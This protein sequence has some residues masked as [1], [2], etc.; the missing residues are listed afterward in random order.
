LDPFIEI[1]DMINEYED[2]IL[3]IFV[4]WYNYDNAYY[5]VFNGD[6]ISVPVIY[7][8]EHISEENIITYRTNE[9]LVR[10][11]NLRCVATFVIYPELFYFL[12]YFDPIEM[13]EAD[14]YG[15][16]FRR[17]D[18]SYVQTLTGG[19]KHYFHAITNDLS[20]FS[21][22]SQFCTARPTWM[23]VFS[24]SYV[25]V[26]MESGVIRKTVLLEKFNGNCAYSEEI[27][28][29]CSKSVVTNCTR[30]ELVDQFS[31]G[32]SYLEWNGITFNLKMSDS[33]SISVPISQFELL[34]PPVSGEYL[35]PMAIEKELLRA[36]AGNISS[37][38]AQLMLYV[39]VYPFEPLSLVLYP[40]PYTIITTDYSIGFA[41]CDGIGRQLDV[42]MFLQPY[43]NASWG[44]ILIFTCII[45][46]TFILVVFK[47]TQ[48]VGWKWKKLE[49]FK[50][51]SNL[52]LYHISNLLETPP[53]F[54]HIFK[55]YPKIYTLLRIPLLAWFIVLLVLV[56]A[57]KGII[58][59]GL[60]APIPQTNFYK[61]FSQTNGFVFATKS[62][63]PDFTL[64]RYF[65]VRLNLLHLPFVYLGTQYVYEI[66]CN[67]N[68]DTI[69]RMLSDEIGMVHTENKTWAME[70]KHSIMESLK[71]LELRE[72]LRTRFNCSQ[73]ESSFRHDL[74][75]NGI[76]NLFGIIP[77]DDTKSVMNYSISIAFS[78]TLSKSSRFASMLDMTRNCDKTGI[79]AD[80]YE[81]NI[82]SQYAKLKDKNLVFMSGRNQILQTRSGYSFHGIYAE[83]VYKQ[84]Q[85]LMSNGII[86]HILDLTEKSKKLRDRFV[87]S[88]DRIA[89]QKLA[90]D[91][92]GS[93]SFL[94][95]INLIFLDSLILILEILI[96]Y[97]YLY[98]NYFK[99]Q[100]SRF[101]VY[102]STTLWNFNPCRQIKWRFVMLLVNSHNPLI[103]VL[104][105]KIELP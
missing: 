68:L 27:E 89:P 94:I 28:I 25:F 69:E 17:D 100:L 4:P 33:P 29:E 84:S 30:R 73:N 36:I 24:T 41:T 8:T 39:G 88:L 2:C 43:D 54:P 79:L 13:S 58:A 61:E 6:L 48:P 98:K 50:L 72:K 99:K 3:N 91:G 52:L 21:T 90:L 82:F 26:I 18:W 32:E 66:F 38:A 80:E 20:L 22:E 15:V 42:E 70:K 34:H 76:H 56:N 63:V 59:T 105:E 53:V 75:T 71:T 64:G 45:M 40:T 14:I 51:Y 92:S 81:L 77:F 37:V 11:K 65:P 7:R 67:E 47:T 44:C 102:I 16:V 83:L 103:S 78:E 55:K 23:G 46:P 19:M 86:Q 62:K 97:F 74:E 87:T 57:Y 35:V 12:D 5:R 31:I 101:H 95:L 49:V 1:S 104:G 9:T 96:F 93:I 85:L 10:G 60:T